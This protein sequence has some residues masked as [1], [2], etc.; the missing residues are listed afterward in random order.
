MKDAAA[1]DD[2]KAYYYQVQVLEEDK[3]GPGKANEKV[4]GKEAN[5][6]KYSGSLMD[7]RCGAMRYA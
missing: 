4:K 7:V 5:K 1:R 2:P 6:A 3:Q